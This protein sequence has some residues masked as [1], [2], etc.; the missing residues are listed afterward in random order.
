MRALV[1]SGIWPPDVGGPA[2]HAPD[3]CAFLAGRGHRVESV[4]T[5]DA[6]PPPS[7][8][9]VHWVSRRLPPGLRHAAVVAEIARRAR[10]ADVVYTTGMFARSAGASLVVRRP[11]VV[12][13]T[14]DPAFERA[15]WRGYVGG[16]VGA[17][18]LGGGGLQAAVLRRLRDGTLRRAAHVLCPSDYLAR[19]AVG[20]GVRPE[21]VSVLPNP[22]PAAPP[23]EEREAL[24]AR[25]GLDGPTLAFAGRLTA[26]KSLDVALEAL[27]RT[28]GVEF[29]V[30]G[31]G[32]ERSRLE[33]RTGELG[34]DGRVRFLGPQPHSLVLE[35][36]AASDAALLP[37]S[38]ENFPHSVVEALGVGTP[39]LATYV[40]G[41]AEVVRN[42][43]NGLLVPPGDP[44][45]LAGAIER[46]F[47]EGALRERLRAAALPS[48]AAYAPERV[49]ARVEQVLHA[50][51]RRA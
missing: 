36:F 4:V 6:P 42:E 31:D 38:W 3:L 2:T 30:V 37:S 44:R 20:W 10:A 32:G 12:K 23:A 51:A 25:H 13:L 24:R 1:V 50:V 26:Q 14:G 7:D 47:S 48:V 16:E 46:F 9:P 39:V 41:V 49:F 19:L 33:R 8:H 15:R 17:F 11:Y 21:H 40:G 43:E 22:G 34:L 29:V 5:A 28:P 45:A 18:Q 27:V 35:L